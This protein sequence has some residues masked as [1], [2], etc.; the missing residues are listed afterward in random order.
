VEQHRESNCEEI[1]GELGKR[2]KMYEIEI[3][4]E[5]SRGENPLLFGGKNQDFLFFLHINIVVVVELFYLKN[6]TF[7][8]FL[9]Y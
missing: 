9:T 6:H 3:K 2:N 1:D 7:L 4:K 5:E 8:F